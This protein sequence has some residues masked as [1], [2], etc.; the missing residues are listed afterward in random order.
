M[1]TILKRI[2]EIAAEI[3]GAGRLG[4]HIEH[5]PR[6]R[7]FSAGTS[8]VKSVRHRRHG[9]AF[10]QGSLGSC[11]GNAMAG[12]LMTEPLWKPGR[13]LTEKDAVKLYKAATRLDSIPGVYPPDDTGSSG[14]AVMKA[15]VKAKYITGYAHTFS[16]QQLLGSLVR[17]P[18]ILGINWYDSF[19]QPR[20]DGECRLTSHARNRGGH[21]VQLFGID[22]KKRQVWCFNSWGSTWGAKRNGTFWFS[23]KTLERLLDERGDATFPR[24]GG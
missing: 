19:D 1:K 11:T 8:A 4:R 20:S 3:A 14:L 5:D 2:K 15:A 21:E 7:A 23:Y 9:K 16:L 13:T 12:A 6:S 17:Y 24:I 18:G 22:V 10:Q